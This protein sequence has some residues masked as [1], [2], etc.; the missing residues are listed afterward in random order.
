M[1][2]SVTSGGGLAVALATCCMTPS[3]AQE[4]VPSSRNFVLTFGQ[5]FRATENLDLD[6]VSAGTTYRAT[7]RLGFSAE[8][9]NEVTQL[10]LQTSTGFAFTEPPSGASQSD[11]LDP[12]LTF[13]YNRDG[14]TSTISADAQYR[15]EDIEFIRP[16][17][18][19]I[20]EEGVLDLPD[21][22]LDLRD[23]GRRTDLAANVAVTLRR[24]APLSFTLSAGTNRREYS[25]VTS[26]SLFDSTTDRFGALA[27]LRID[28]ATNATLSWSASRYSA[29][30][31]QNTRRD[32]D[33]LS[34]GVDRDFSEVLSASARVGLSRIDSE[35]N[36][37]ETRQ[38]ATT[39]A[40]NLQ[41]ARP[42][43]NIGLSY[44]TNLTP[45]GR[46]ESYGLTRSLSLPSA[47]LNA[48]AGVTRIEGGDG[49]DPTVSLSYNQSLPSGGFSL[50]VNRTVRFDE[51]TDTDRTTTSF[52]AGYNFTI[53]PVSSI[54]LRGA[55]T[56]REDI[57]Q[58]N[59]S[60]SYSHALTE[61]W[62][63][64]SGYGYRRRVESGVPADS[65]SIFVS[66]SRRFDLP[67]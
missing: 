65:H 59:L 7:T 63:L 28:G 48:S 14:A 52:S 32:S 40:L 3:V 53:N 64:N 15:S 27:R 30:D 58:T 66:L 41:L 10:D 4:P 16:L 13:S 55:Y 17:E 12:R 24:D 43:G 49:F 31:V 57:D 6:P 56:E 19:F 1:I 23:T 29:E 45:S 38:E 36:G 67:F 42:N 25:G 61:D 46:R 62:S 22:A 50:G 9:Q 35:E 47:E 51:V 18:D 5:E 60:V 37:V 33:S 20:D 39:A 26:T 2:R 54:S 11:F 34:L 44:S 21:D 8:I